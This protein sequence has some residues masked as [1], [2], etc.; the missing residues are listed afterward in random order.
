[1]LEVARKGAGADCDCDAEPPSIT[2]PTAATS[3]VSTTALTRAIEAGRPAAPFYLM[4]GRRGLDPGEVRAWLAG[5]GV[6]ASS[7]A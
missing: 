3:D 1:M 2:L 5:Q 6:E 7:E 4:A